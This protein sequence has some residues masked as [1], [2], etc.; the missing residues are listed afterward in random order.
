MNPLIPKPLSGISIWS[1]VLAKKIV[2]TKEN[3][4]TAR[5]S[6][7]ESK[8]NNKWTQASEHYHSKP[9]YWKNFDLQL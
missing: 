8:Q 7:S 5:L 4:D 6:I 1:R 3:L 9:E 2:Y